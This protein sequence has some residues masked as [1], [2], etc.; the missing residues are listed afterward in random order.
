MRGHT[1]RGHE[2]IVLLLRLEVC[3][4]T[5]HRSIIYL[6]LVMY[7]EARNEHTLCVNEKV[8]RYGA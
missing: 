1:F 3:A 4:D 5:Y 8:E 2:G 6:L 7:E